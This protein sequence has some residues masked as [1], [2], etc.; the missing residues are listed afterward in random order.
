MFGGFGKIGK[1]NHRLVERL[2]PDCK[3]GE[4]IPEGYLNFEEAKQYRRKFL[5][6]PTRESK[7]KEIIVDEL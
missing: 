5:N 6:V 2:A 1:G 7:W 4:S 3:F